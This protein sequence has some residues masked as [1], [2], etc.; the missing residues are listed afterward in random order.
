[1]RIIYPFNP[2]NEQEADEP[3]QEEFSFMKSQ[4]VECS[5]FDFDALYLDEFRPKPQLLS[6]EIVLYR[7]WML[8]P[9]RYQKLINFITKKGAIPFTTYENYIKCH[10]LPNWY[11]SCVELTAESRFFSNDKELEVNVEA[12]GWGEYFVKDFVKSNSTKRGSIA[13][14]PE[15]VREIVE[16]INTYRGEIEGGIAVR[17]VESYDEDTE[18]RYFVFNG[19]AYSPDGEIP[20]IVLNIAERVNASFYSVDIIQ[21]NDG[22][23]R[24]VEIGDGQVSDKKTWSTKTFSKMV[25]ENA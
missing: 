21:R 18:T 8:N 13:S 10:H 14:S 9:E 17:R 3:Y 19:R 25:L 5:L 24:L 16:L 15:E 12:L 2:F 7:G 11:D 1:M 6:D 4:S 20:E 23:Y 22:I